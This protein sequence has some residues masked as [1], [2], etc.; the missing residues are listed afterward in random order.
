[1]KRFIYTLIISTIVL[2]SCQQEVEENPLH[3]ELQEAL[4]TAS[5]GSGVDFFRL[6]DANDFNRIPCYLPSV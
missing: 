3:L 5:N 6:P 4:Q 1:M 2:A